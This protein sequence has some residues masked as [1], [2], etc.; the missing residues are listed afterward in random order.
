MKMKD[1]FKKPLF[2]III[3]SLLIV[4]LVIGLCVAFI[5]RSKKSNVSNNGT[6]GFTEEQIK[7]FKDLE[8]NSSFDKS[9]ELVEIDKNILLDSETISEVFYL[10]DDYMVVRVKKTEGDIVPVVTESIEV[11]KKTIDG[12]QRVIGGISLIGSEYDVIYVTG[13]YAIISQRVKMI[14]GSAVVY[15]GIMNLQ[16]KSL[17]VDFGKYDISY[18]VNDLV[19]LGY[20]QEDSRTFDVYYNGVHT[21]SYSNVVLEME[22]E[23]VLNLYSKDQFYMIGIKNNQFCELLN[24]QLQAQPCA[25][26]EAVFNE[27]DTYYNFVTLPLVSYLK[28]DLY[29]VQN[30]SGDYT[31]MQDISNYSYFLSVEN[32]E[33]LRQEYT[34]YYLDANLLRNDYVCLTYSDASGNKDNY[35][36]YLNTEFKEIWTYEGDGYLDFTFGDL[37]IF[38]K[39][40][41]YDIANSKLEIF[42][43]SNVRPEI[44]N[45]YLWTDSGVFDKHGNA[46]DF[47]EYNFVSNSFGEYR[48]ASILTVYENESKRQ[49]FLINKAGEKKEIENVA[50]EFEGAML[51]NVGFYVI[52]ADG[53]FIL[54]DLEK[55]ESHEFQELRYSIQGDKL[56]LFGKTTGVE[57]IKVF[58]YWICKTISNNEQSD[59]N[60]GEKLDETETNEN[61]DLVAW[62]SKQVNVYV[63]YSGSTHF[64]WDLD[65]RDAEK[66]TSVTHNGK[67]FT[68]YVSYT[69]E[70]SGGF[71]ESTI[72]YN[73]IIIIDG[74][75][76]TGFER[77]VKTSSGEEVLTSKS[78]LDW[79]GLE[80]KNG[81]CTYYLSTVKELW[82]DVYVEPITYNLYLS[83]RYGDIQDNRLPVTYHSKYEDLPDLN[84]GYI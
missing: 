7:F 37:F 59:N 78:N 23:N 21:K 52:N 81:Q 10:S 56:Y 82:I 83:S 6:D 84:L 29:F 32:G 61:L 48:L 11:M 75:K 30:L 60:I 54:F 73:G 65:K 9:G 64:N 50:S 40:D 63:Y 41:V 19:A 2:Y 18:F 16:N 1:L 17:I 38:K 47:N 24:I 71:F 70:L 34:S 14:D 67:T 20:S 44:G 72:K 49:W 62:S 26:N 69:S 76:V 25:E 79:D 31:N 57:S 15:Y 8:I 22:L 36:V 74:Y 27:L 46:V 35:N 55:N 4:G 39:G 68:G 58:N 53:C 45:D 66:K 28:D 3:S 51:L 5:P 80:T 12:T 33:K 13:D 77:K 42:A 43:S